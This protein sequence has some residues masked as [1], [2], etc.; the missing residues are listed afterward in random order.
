MIYVWYSY[1]SFIDALATAVVAAH[2]HCVRPIMVIQ[3]NDNNT[4]W[5]RMT[6]LR[7]DTF[8]DMNTLG[9]NVV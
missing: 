7:H 3:T 9:N 4:G 5:F 8:T 2:L 6:T 1:T